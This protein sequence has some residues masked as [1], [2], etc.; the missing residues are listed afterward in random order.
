MNT[1]PPPSFPFSPRP[2]VTLLEQQC[3]HVFTTCLCPTSIQ[4]FV[5][6]SSVPSIFLLSPHSTPDN[7]GIFPLILCNFLSLPILCHVS[8]PSDPLPLCSWHS[9]TAVERKP[10]VR[11]R[12]GSDSGRRNE[13]VLCPSLCSLHEASMGANGWNVFIQG[14][15]QFT[16]CPYCVQHFKICSIIMLWRDD[17]LKKL[18]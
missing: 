7:L 18:L 1:A 12:E 4:P 3:P 11:R 5:P 9:S 17:K 13:E 10:S 6:H 2:V 14:K 8:L 16:D 15:R